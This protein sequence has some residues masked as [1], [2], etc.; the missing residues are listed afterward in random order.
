MKDHK[1][2]ILETERDRLERT[3]FCYLCLPRKLGPSFSYFRIRNLYSIQYICSFC[4]LLNSP[5]VLALFYWQYAFKKYNLFSLSQ[6]SSKSTTP[7]SCLCWCIGFHM[8]DILYSYF[9]RTIL[10]THPLPR[11]SSKNSNQIPLA[12]SNGFPFVYGSFPAYVS[13]PVSQNY[14]HVGT[15]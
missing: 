9:L 4:F 5:L 3:C 14:P 1:G 2:G 13:D 12:P 7:P 11:A 8:V 6:V 15:H 10:S